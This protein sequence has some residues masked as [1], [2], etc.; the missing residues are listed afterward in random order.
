MVFVRLWKLLQLSDHLCY[1]MRALSVK[2][3]PGTHYKAGMCSVFSIIK[4]RGTGK[5]K[6]STV[7]WNSRDVLYLK[8]ILKKWIWNKKYSWIPILRNL[9]INCYASFDKFHKVE[10]EWAR[11]V[12]YRSKQGAYLCSWHHWQIAKKDFKNLHDIADCLHSI[13]MEE[14]RKGFQS[15]FFKVVVLFHDRLVETFW[16]LFKTKADLQNV[17]K[18]QSRPVCGQNANRT[19]CQTSCHYW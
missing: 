9:T 13:C 4:V 10:Q 1:K 11:L 18:D 19:K 12:F 5:E 6:I 2:E 14:S 16:D 3:N 8:G 15:D 7:L 17:D